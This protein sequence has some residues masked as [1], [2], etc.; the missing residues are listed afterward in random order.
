MLT[1]PAQI[2]CAPTRAKLIAALRLMPGVCGVFGSSEWPGI[3]CTPSCFHL[4]TEISLGAP[5]ALR[6]GLA[7]RFLVWPV[8]VSPAPARRRVVIAISSLAL[9]P[10]PRSALVR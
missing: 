3:T 10:L 6:A 9:L 2:F 1:V 8:V 5:A 4:G 7:C